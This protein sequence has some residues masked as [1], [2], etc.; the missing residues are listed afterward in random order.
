MSTNRKLRIALAIWAVAFPVVSCAPAILADGITGTLLGGLFGLVLGS[1][2]LVPW[3]IGLVV[4]GALVYLT[5]ERRDRY[6]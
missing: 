3:L 4:L 5:D 2:L 6:R 1:V